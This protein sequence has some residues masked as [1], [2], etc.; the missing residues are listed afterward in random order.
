VG[1]K[2]E[3]SSRYSVFGEEG[4]ECG[5]FAVGGGPEVGRRKSVAGSRYSVKRGEECGQFAVGGGPEVGSQ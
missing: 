1:R 4:G 3:V 5:R 2:T